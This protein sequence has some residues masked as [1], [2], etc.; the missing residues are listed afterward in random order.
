MADIIIVSAVG[1]KN[2]DDA[3]EMKHRDLGRRCAKFSICCH[4]PL[5][6][7]RLPFDFTCDH[8]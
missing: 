1:P 2:H 6:V 7:Y 4:H 8:L 5:L 3:N